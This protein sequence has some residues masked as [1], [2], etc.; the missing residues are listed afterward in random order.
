MRSL[1]I[2]RSDTCVEGTLVR[3][4]DY[5]DR[6]EREEP[7]T[8]A[9]MI[10]R[11]FTI[12]GTVEKAAEGLARMVEEVRKTLLCHTQLDYERWIAKIEARRRLLK[13][14]LGYVTVF[15]ERN[16]LDYPLLEED[17]ISVAKE[18]LKSMENLPRNNRAK[19]TMV[20][21]AEAGYYMHDLIFIYLG[22]ILNSL[23]YL[24]D[25]HRMLNES[26][27]KRCQRYHQML[28]D[29]LEHEG[30]MDQSHF[31]KELD[32]FIRQN[33]D[34]K[35]AL[36]AFQ[37]QLEHEALN[38]PK[39]GNVA[40]I[41]HHFLNQNSHVS[42]IF[43]SRHEL[44]QDEINRH[45]YFVCCWNHVNKKIE[46]CILKEPA[47]GAYANLFTSRAAQELTK[48]LT[49]TISMK[50]DFEHDYLYA[51]C[52]EAMKDT[53]LIYKKKRNGTQ[54]TNFVNETFGEQIENSTL[55][56]YLKPEK[57]DEFKK[58]E[59][60]Y[61]LILS[62]INQALGREPMGENNYFENESDEF[63]ERLET[64]RKAL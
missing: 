61:N 39:H 22:R 18:K 58:I 59:G 11:L 2:Y 28:I 24:Y 41:N 44:T 31:L 50:V 21:V 62:I 42:Y 46:L 20:D 27:E 37:K 63:F 1:I 8:E 3:L 12:Y 4:L 47:V 32:D 54:V 36:N 9:E 51:A 53:G 17:D 13:K 38:H 45:L 14:T 25:D 30:V 35:E 7:L 6:M 40:I 34:D 43:H 16:K 56:R 23:Q 26:D 29:Y 5:C 33:G 57:G 64:L 60:Q 52:A 10:G 55:A 48:L 49:P 19:R 15:A